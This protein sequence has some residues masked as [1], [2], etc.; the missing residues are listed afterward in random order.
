MALCDSTES[1]AVPR[2]TGGDCDDAAQRLH[3]GS[4]EDRKG[5][6]CSSSVTGAAHVGVPFLTRWGGVRGTSEI[7]CHA[8]QGTG[9]SS[10][11]TALPWRLS[12]VK[13]V[14]SVLF[15]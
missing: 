12:G 6:V 15:C 3:G 14:R 2:W 1:A 9:R 13:T 10:D 4:G 11:C 7:I 8:P 5:H